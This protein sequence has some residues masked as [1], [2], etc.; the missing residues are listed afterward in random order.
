LNASYVIAGGFGGIG[1]AILRWMAARGARHLIVPSPNGPSSK[2]ALDLVSE[3]TGK[4]VRLTTS[5]CNAGK[6]AELSALLEG[7]MATMPPIKGCINA[8]MVL[9]DSIFENM[10]HIQWSRTMQSKVDTS[11]NLHRL[12]PSNMDFFILL[13]S[14]AGIHGSQGQSNYAAGCAFQDSLARSRTVAG[15]RGSVAL[16]LGRMGSIGII[17]ENEAYRHNPQ[18]AALME[19]VS[20]LDLLALLDHFCDPSLP[21]VDVDHTQVLIGVVTPQDFY[22]R[23]DMTP[24]MLK[25]PMLAGFDTSHILAAGGQGAA[26]LEGTPAVLFQQAKTGSDRSIAVVTGLKAKLARALGAEIDEVDPRRSLS[27]YGTDS[28]MAVELRNWIRND[29]G[30]TV[31]VFEIMGGTSIAAVGELVVMKARI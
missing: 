22:A 26:G 27:D 15:H 21:L 10:V 12:L 29:F 3:L 30:V 2:Q 13:S 19:E 16:N 6:E 9:Q 8:A 20:K 5:C 18:H 1:R 31:S 4:G 11:W 17:A 28:L 23:G 25:R 24:E 7:S 14:V